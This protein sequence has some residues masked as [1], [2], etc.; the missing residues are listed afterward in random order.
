[1]DNEGAIRQL[2]ETWMEA[3]KVFHSIR[4]EEVRKDEVFELYSCSGAQISTS[5]SRRLRTVRYLQFG[6]RNSV[7]PTTHEPLLRRIAECRRALLARARTRDQGIE[8]PP[9]TVPV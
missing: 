7:T 3:T 6:D 1:M 2:D 5:C 8:G 9:K 4:R